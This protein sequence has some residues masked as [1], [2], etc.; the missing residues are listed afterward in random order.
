MPKKN[1]ANK[2]E[3]RS[4][5]HS[6]DIEFETMS[7]AGGLRQNKLGFAGKDLV[8]LI[9]SAESN[10]YV[11]FYR[12]IN[13]N[14][15]DKI[16]LGTHAGKGL[17]VKG[18]S[19]NFGPI[20]GEVPLDPRLSKLFEQEKPEDTPEE[21]PPYKYYY[22]EVSDQ[23]GNDTKIKNAA[24]EVTSEEESKKFLDDYGDYKFCSAI[25]KTVKVLQINNVETGALEYRLSYDENQR[26]EH[27]LYY[28]RA[29]SDDNVIDVKSKI[30]STED[31]KKP[32][33]AIKIEG[34]FFFL[35]LTSGTFSKNTDLEREATEFEQAEVEVLSYTKFSPKFVD[36]KI[37]LNPKKYVITAD[38]DELA[39]SGQKIIPI[40][41]HDH[42]S[43]ISRELFLKR[44]H[45]MMASEA[46]G[47]HESDKNKEFSIRNF[48]AGLGAVTEIERNLKTTLKID[49]NASTSHG[50]EI[51]NPN[52]EPFS[53]DDDYPVIIPNLRIRDYVIF[54]LQSAFPAET[55]F[56]FC[57]L[58]SKAFALK[59]RGEAQIMFMFNLL[60]EVGYPLRVNPK[61][62]WI[63]KDEEPSEFL[64]NP[65]IAKIDKDK[66]DSVDEVHHLELP[67]G[68]AKPKFRSLEKRK[69][70][71]DWT[72][73][74]DVVKKGIN[75]YIHFKKE[76][77]GKIVDEFTRNLDPR[78]KDTILLM[79][80][81][82]AKHFEKDYLLKAVGESREGEIEQFQKMILKLF[83]LLEKELG[84]YIYKVKNHIEYFPTRKFNKKDI[85][86]MIAGR[87]LKVS[88][89]NDYDEQMTENLSEIRKLVCEVQELAPGKLKENDLITLFSNFYRFRL[90]EIIQNQ[91]LLIS[92]LESAPTITYS[93]GG[94]FASLPSD[95]FRNDKEY[96]DLIKN[97]DNNSLAGPEEKRVK[98]M[99]RLSVNTGAEFEKKRKE[100]INK[101]KDG[102]NS[103]IRIF[104]DLVDSE[105]DLAKYKQSILQ[106]SAVVGEHTRRL[107]AASSSQRKGREPIN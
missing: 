1:R 85:P 12:P 37:V 62:N 71:I 105:T 13:K 41:N 43:G 98:A 45:I 7:V 106:D 36:G 48:F 14:A 78:L 18:K 72:E 59:L 64:V 11:S 22:D 76:L 102:L 68:I 5:R 23:L 3:M 87:I 19:S 31:P 39:S 44:R 97:I 104:I 95:Q 56:G 103:A 69:K 92:E 50:P 100:E 57:A 25:K 79:K 20:A 35:D 16:E 46:L 65:M 96:I 33:F 30:L 67:D 49:T 84:N 29:K 4:A 55:R 28:F 91:M 53:D 27:I 26:N 73:I 75:R 54:R 82:L 99:L 70:E 101:L 52:P 47:S 42:I 90:N 77:F 6:R 38:Y 63:L 15:G 21:K 80:K 81:T 8:N 32:V 94:F 83:G 89:D 17:N 60:R 51:G 66:I 34:K 58:D 107:N 10:N 40:A 24:A 93:W 86:A 74:T 9:K 88:D 61:W 2:E